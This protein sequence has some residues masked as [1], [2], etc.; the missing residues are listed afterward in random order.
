MAG[1]DLTGRRTNR[2]ISVFW[3]ILAMGAGVFALLAI[4]L[5]GTNQAVEPIEYDESAEITVNEG[6]T[7]VNAVG[8]TEAAANDNDP[9]LTDDAQTVSGP[10][11][12]GDTPSEDVNAEIDAA[13]GEGGGVDAEAVEAVEGEAA[14][15]EGIVEPALEEPAAE[16]AA[17]DEAIV[18]E[19]PAEG[20][21]VAPGQGEVVVDPDGTSAPA[22]PTPSGPEGRD[23]ETIAD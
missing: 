23:D 9:T 10:Q 1:M 19:A 6:E 12:E 2:G 14:V 17:T 13:A 18:D 7:Q 5:V 4:L 22:V 16:E 11:P 8:N 21:A 3:M 20:E 15:E